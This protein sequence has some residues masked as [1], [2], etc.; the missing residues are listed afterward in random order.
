MGDVCAAWDAGDDREVANGSAEETDELKG[1]RLSPSPERNVETH[2]SCVSSIPL[3]HPLGQRHRRAEWFNQRA[4]DRLR[5]LVQN[6]VNPL[7]RQTLHI[8]TRRGR[9]VCAEGE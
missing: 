8:G 1:S 3:A 6:P 5:P 7:D 2:R 4:T 9:R